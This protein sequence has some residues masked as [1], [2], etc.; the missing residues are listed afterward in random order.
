MRGLVLADTRHH[1]GLSGED[2]I[3]LVRLGWNEGTLI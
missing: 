3:E 1:L 2:R